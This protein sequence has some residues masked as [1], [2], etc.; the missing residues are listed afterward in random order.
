MH[1]NIMPYFDKPYDPNYDSSDSESDVSKNELKHLNIY[2]KYV[3]G[4]SVRTLLDNY[5]GF[6]ENVIKMYLV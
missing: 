4:G 3:P 1:P 5:G 6:H 2:M